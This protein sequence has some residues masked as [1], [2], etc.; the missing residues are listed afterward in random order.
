MS[1]GHLISDSPK[2]SCVVIILGYI[3]GKCI[4]LQ[5]ISQLSAAHTPTF[6]DTAA[7]FSPRLGA[8]RRVLLTFLGMSLPLCIFEKLT[9]AVQNNVTIR[10]LPHPTQAQEEDLPVLACE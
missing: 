9:P 2:L 1:G 6:A 5:R 7:A 3:E 10:F 4:H 8:H